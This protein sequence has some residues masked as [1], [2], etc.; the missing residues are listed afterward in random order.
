MLLILLLRTLRLIVNAK[1][2]TVASYGFRN[3]HYITI[4]LQFSP[5]GNSEVVCVTSPKYRT[6]KAKE[7]SLNYDYSKQR[8]ERKGE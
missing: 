2:D 1:L 3:L 6:W 4:N 7:D 8:R 5:S